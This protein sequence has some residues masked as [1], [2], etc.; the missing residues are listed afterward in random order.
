VLSKESANV[1]AFDNRC[2]LLAVNG[3]E[4]VS[5][6]C[7]ICGYLVR[8]AIGDNQV[9]NDAEERENCPLTFPKREQLGQ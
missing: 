8:A 7:C 5:C 2:E 1:K 9:N 3:T 4:R 6:S